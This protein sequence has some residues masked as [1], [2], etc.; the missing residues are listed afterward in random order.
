M[1]RPVDRL[2][3]AR[4]LILV[5][6]DIVVFFAVLTLLIDL[7]DPALLRFDVFVRLL[8]VLVFCLTAA[9][10]AGL[11]ELRLIRDFV[12]LVGGVLASSVSSWVL[13][14]SYFYLLSPY[15]KFAPRITL[16]LIVAGTH[17]G[18]LAWRRALLLVTGFSLVDLRI[19]TL[20]HD[21][22]RDY[23]RSS[24]R[25]RFNEGFN[26]VSTVT[27]DVN[28]VVV[29]RQWADRHPGEARR[30]LA[31]AIASR[32]PIVGIDEFYESLFGKVS[33]QHANDLAWALDH[34]LPRCGSLYFKAKRLLD[35]A[36]AAVLLVILTPAM[37]LIAIAIRLRDQVSPFYGQT[38][39]GYLGRTFVLWKFQTMRPYAD[40]EGPF[41][42]R[43]ESK[44]P[45]V[46]RLGYILRRLR[47]D[48]L[49]QLWNV[50]KGDMSLV[51]PRPEWIKEV[52]ILEKAVP[53]YSLR[54]LVPPGI[55][56]WAQ[57]YFRATRDPQD[58]IEKHSFDLYYLKH[59]S[60][61]LD[62]SIMLKT[63]KRILVKD[64]RVPVSST[65]Y[66]LMSTPD[67]DLR[68]DVASIVSR[69]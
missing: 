32:I 5:A 39:I 20:A 19:V 43:P 7:R 45:R 9:Y 62:F 68:V 51:G 21:D 37:L 14:A 47:L 61:A 55:T 67:S 30:A 3:F 28:L 58:S 60:L 23:L 57:V 24:L 34:V 2:W 4:K 48:E 10:A 63:V 41:S 35:V 26:L 56:G 31:A 69:K 33:P 13:G 38:R 54:Y 29:D 44:D 46:T 42:H 18:M 53:T 17:V 1:M 22:H 40:E 64:S 36:A 49:P 12:A 50:V 25:E 11:Y 65:P 27:A 66:P 59:F 16:F 6:G 15:L 8:P 52:E